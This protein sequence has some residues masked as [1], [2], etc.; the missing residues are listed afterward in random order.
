MQLLSK[1]R[2]GG[3]RV[4]SLVNSYS[5]SLNAAWGSQGGKDEEQSWTWPLGF[6]WTP[7]RPFGSTSSNSM[8][9]FPGTGNQTPAKS[10][11]HCHCAQPPRPPQ[12]WRPPTWDQ[13]RSRQVWPL[14]SLISCPQEAT[15]TAASSYCKKSQGV[16]TH[17][18]P[19]RAWGQRGRQC[20]ILN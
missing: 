15:C 13:L 4:R 7:C 11:F 20:Y 14:S 19:P 3:R 8:V 12:F 1:D 18:L 9:Q 17:A 2:A 5:Q 6:K 10:S 16:M